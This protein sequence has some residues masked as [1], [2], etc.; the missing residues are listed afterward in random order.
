MFVR[1]AF[2]VAAHLRV[3]T[4]L[5]DE[6]LS[7]GDQEFQKKCLG[8]MGEVAKDGRTV[9]LVSHNMAAI[10]NLCERVLLLQDG[11]LLRDGAPDDIIAKYLSGARNNQSQND[12]S[13]IPRAKNYKPILK[14]LVC[15]NATGQ[16]CDSIL[17]GE[18]LELR[19]KYECSNNLKSPYFGFTF[20]N[21][22]GARLFTVQTAQNHG[23]IEVLPESGEVV[24]R[25]PRF[26]LA[27]GHYT[28]SIGAGAQGQT[29]DVLEQAL[30]FEVH[31]TDV[32]GTGVLLPA[33]HSS[34]L[35]DSKW[36]FSGGTV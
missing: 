31:H 4:L 35:V 20:M 27:P 15:V 7:V 29:I 12:L 21:H 26:P 10:Q 32:F 14:E 30:G 23:S 1:L 28:I 19:L 13:K 5:V 24:C 34:F 36:E 11:K 2:A 17:A 16:S 9:V 25:I 33:Q 8:K 22:L 6:V 3:D 18:S